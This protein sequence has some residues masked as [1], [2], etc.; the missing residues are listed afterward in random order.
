MTRSTVL[1]LQILL[2]FPSNT[3]YLVQKY[4]TKGGGTNRDKPTSLMRHVVNYSCNFFYSG[5]K[6]FR[7]GF[8]LLTSTNALAYYIAL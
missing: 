6:L 8:K 5:N 7:L 3:P 1:S 2:V 4:L